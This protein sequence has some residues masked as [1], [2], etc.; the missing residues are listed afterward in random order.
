MTFAKLGVAAAGLRGLHRSTWLTQGLIPAAA[1]FPLGLVGAVVVLAA[2]VLLVGAFVDAG[3]LFVLEIL[4]GVGVVLV[5][6]LG[7][8]PEFQRKLKIGITR[9]Q[10]TTKSPV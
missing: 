2:A 5:D 6:A 8:T 3:V 4:D 1:L 9:K 10:L 7:V